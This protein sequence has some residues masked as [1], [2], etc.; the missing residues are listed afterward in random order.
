VL[1]IPLP[2]DLGEAGDGRSRVHR[3]RSLDLRLGQDLHA[4]RTRYGL[5]QSEVAKV[6]SA[7]G[8]PTISQWEE[9]QNVPDGIRRERLRELLAGELWPE[10]R[11]SLI[12]GDGMPMRWNQG[13]RSYRRASRERVLRQGVGVIVSALLDDLR[14]VDSGEALRLHY[15]AHDG[16]WAHQWAD[17]PGHGHECRDDLRRLEDASYGLRWLE[18]ARGVQF[19]LTASLVRQLPLCFLEMQQSERVQHVATSDPCADAGILC[20][21]AVIDASCSSGPSRVNHGTR[22]HGRHLLG[23]LET[24]D[25]FAVSRS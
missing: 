20:E 9:G 16:D 6:L 23:E 21:E 5:T 2:K 13:V 19:N 24:T 10:L 25:A 17:Q 3:Y 1:F 8:A 11:A 18:I 12:H 4:F 14:T 7:G 15:V 22:A